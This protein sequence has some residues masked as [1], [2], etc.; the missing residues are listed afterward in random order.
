[1]Y[2]EFKPGTVVGVKFLGVFKHVGIVSD[3]HMAG[4]PAILNS[5]QRTGFALEEPLSKFLDARE[6][7]I[8][9]TPSAITPLETVRNA[10]KS[11]GEKWSWFNNCEHYVYEALGQGKKSPQLRTVG[12][13]LAAGISLYAISK[14]RD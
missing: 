3:R 6:L 7:Q 9:D 14:I 4:E 2:S 8:L 13:L 1:M 10:R 5:S 12:I 11:L